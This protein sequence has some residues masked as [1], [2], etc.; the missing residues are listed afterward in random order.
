MIR[1]LAKFRA[2]Y[3]SSAADYDHTAHLTTFDADLPWFSAGAGEEWI[4]VDLGVPSALQSVRV[5]WGPSFARRVILQVSDDGRAWSPLAETAGAADAPCETPV[6]GTGRFLRVL[7]RDC[8]G[9][10]YVIRRIQI[11]GEN[12]GGYALPPLPAPAADGSQPLTGGNWRIARAQQVSAEGP[13]LSQPDFDDSAWLPATVPGT[14]L[15]SFLNTGA[16]PDPDFDDNQFQISEAYFTADFWYRDR[17][18]VAEE[19]RGRRVYLDFDAVNWKA[20]VFFNGTF[21]ANENPQ[22]AHSI[23]GAFIRSRFDITDLVRFGAENGLAVRVHCNDTPGAVTTQ[24]LAYGPG[25]NGGL[26]GAD[27]PTLHAAVGWDWLPTI[28][29][30]D[31]GLYG[32]VTVRFGGPAEL[33]DPWMET[34]LALLGETKQNPAHDWMQAENARFLGP[35]GDVSHW[36]GREGDALTLDLG[37]VR[38]VGSVTV[39]WGTEKTVGAADLESRHPERYRLERSADGAHWESFDAY[40]GGEVEMRWRG[41]VPAEPN[42]GSPFFEGHAFTDSVQGG[43]AVVELDLSRFGRGVVQQRIFAP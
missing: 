41:L 37:E 33:V 11:F 13:A 14:A 9:D 32:D 23:E 24:G 10:R 1:D 6:S 21:L 30:R 36:R 40:P 27:N 18:P 16:I 7:C 34:R 15:V 31:M 35:E 39:H 3:H 12:E 5:T 4:V 38:T 8:S 17:F 20:D 25:P 43:T 26:L 28:R 19:Q 2:A 42:S 22:R 29:G